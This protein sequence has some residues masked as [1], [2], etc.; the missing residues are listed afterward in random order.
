MDKIERGLDQQ[1]VAGN[2]QAI[3]KVEYGRDGIICPVYAVSRNQPSIGWRNSRDVASLIAYQHTDWVTLTVF[4]P[5]VP[6]AS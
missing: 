4:L 2:P 6:R 5:E 1:I 3:G